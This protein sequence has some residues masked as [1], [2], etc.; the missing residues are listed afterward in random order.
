MGYRGI[1]RKCAA[2]FGNRTP[3]PV[4]VG[5]LTTFLFCGV[6]RVGLVCG[7]RLVGVRPGGTFGAIRGALLSMRAG[8]AMP[9]WCLPQARGLR[10]H[11]GTHG[12]PD[13]CAPHC[14]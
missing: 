13:R 12:G 14:R 6:G 3:E 4:C 8:P 5:W 9:S 2:S 7:R 11:G 1:Q 10:H